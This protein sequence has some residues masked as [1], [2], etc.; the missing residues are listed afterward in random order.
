MDKVF[1][2]LDKNTGLFKEHDNRGKVPSANKSSDEVIA[3]INAITYSKISHCYR[4]T[5]KW[6]YLE[7]N[8]SISK[9]Y[10]Q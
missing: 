3:N 9:M 10:V 4:S 5:T 6:K 7:P 1:E 8:I 2:G